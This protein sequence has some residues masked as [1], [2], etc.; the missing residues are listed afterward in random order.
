MAQDNI[1]LE[2][3][4]TQPINNIITM[5]ILSVIIGVGIYF[6]YPA[7]APVFLASP[8]LNG[9]I[10][11]VFA[12]GLISCFW[13]VLTLINSV[14]WIEGFALD[15]PGHE[16]VAAPGLL[17]SLAAMLSERSARFALTS[18]STQSILGSVAM[19]MDEGREITRYII[20]LLIFLGLLGTFYGLATTVPAVVD[21]IRSL[22][23]QDS[24][25]TSINVFDNLMTGLEAQLGGMGTAFGSSLLGLAG[26][27]IVGLLDI[28][29]GRAQNRFYREM[30][31]WLSSITK[32][33]AA[34]DGEGGSADVSGVMAMTAHQIQTLHDSVINVVDRVDRLAG[35]TEQLIGHISSSQTASVSAFQGFVDGQ[36]RLVEAVQKM[37]TEGEGLVDAETRMRLRNVDERLSQILEEL[38]SGR[39]QST[40][41]LRADLATLAQ[42]LD[43][44][45]KG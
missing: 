13:Q 9:F 34:N 2:G 1:T 39:T 35:S 22:A 44:A 29:S 11:L 10:L 38:G 27:L 8:Y 41:E 4:F 12:A 23:P 17:A 3:R 14:N 20:N 33:G 37:Q 43:E 15:R 40:S 6:A 32:V 18:S 26:S 5:L 25:E 36:N 30:E 16:F 45:T 21:T 28:F 24:N 7:V 42:I 31:D 19:R